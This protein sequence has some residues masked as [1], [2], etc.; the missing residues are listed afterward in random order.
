MRE[1]ATRSQ[2][3][4][5][6]LEATRRFS[7][8]LSFGAAYTYAKSMDSGSDFRAR[9]YNAFDATSFWGP[10][11]SDTRHVAVINFIYQLPW[12]RTSTDWKG[13]LLGGWQVTGVSQFQ[14]GTPFTV[15]TGDDFAGI[16]STDAQPWEING[17]PAMARGDRQFSS[18]AADS[19]FYFLTRNSDGTAIFSTPAAGTFSKTQTRNTLYNPGFQNWNLA[20]FKEFQ[21]KE[22]H[23][24]LAPK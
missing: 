20:L 21:V 13:K 1:T 10:S 23:R 9:L 16:G 7:K 2:Y 19:N 22:N 8:G 18:S 6:Q 5:L 11:D 24:H 3:H 12:L 15:G 14:T 17:N 4:G